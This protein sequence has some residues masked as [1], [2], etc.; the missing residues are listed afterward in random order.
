MISLFMGQPQQWQRLSGLQRQPPAVVSVC[1]LV[2]LGPD[3]V[4]SLQQVLSGMGVEIQVVVVLLA[5]PKFFT[6]FKKSED[7]LRQ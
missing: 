4:L 7:I 1:F 5:V 3:L 6:N 2:A